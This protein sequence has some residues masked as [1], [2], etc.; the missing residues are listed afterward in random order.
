MRNRRSWSGSRAWR[1]P[2]GLGYKSPMPPMASW[3]GAGPEWPPIHSVWAGGSAA[4]DP[5][6]P[7]LIACPGMANP[8]IPSHGCCESRP[9][10]L[11]LPRPGAAAVGEGGPGGDLSPSSRGESDPSEG[12]PG[13]DTDVAAGGA[14]GGGGG[15]AWLGSGAHPCAG[16]EVADGGAG[17]ADGRTMADV[18]RLCPPDK[19]LLATNRAASMARADSL[20][21]PDCGT[22]A[23]YP[24]VTP[25]LAP[26]SSS[27][28]ESLR[29]S[30]SES[31]R[32]LWPQF[33]MC[34]RGGT[35]PL[36]ATGTGG[37]SGPANCG[38]NAKGG[39]GPSSHGRWEGAASVPAAAF[40]AAP[41]PAPAPAAAASASAPAAA[42]LG[43][44]ASGDAAAAS[45]AVVDVAAAA[46]AAPAPPAEWRP[47][48]WPESSESVVP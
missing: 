11:T 22:T 37:A 33:A 18:C 10:N 4:S 46:A 21:R 12:G 6:A 5:S 2:L 44:D 34:A 27:S 48:G 14:D 32:P 41:P 35:N 29:S 30:R 17:G 47:A 7:A 43:R 25:A 26:P 42:R 24:P 23:P 1:A 9:A 38:S 3:P 40:G 15:A 20:G 28:R 31:L 8:G 36:R 16:G 19:D 39:H 45:D 13:G